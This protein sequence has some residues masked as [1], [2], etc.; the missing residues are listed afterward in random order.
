MKLLFTVGLPGSGK[1]TCLEN[2]RKDYENCGESV[3]I[4]DGDSFDDLNK[5]LDYVETIV[6]FNEYDNV[7]V[8]GLFNDKILQ[9]KIA[10]KYR[11]IVER[12]GFIYFIPNI[13]NCLFNDNLR[14]R[15]KK[16]RILIKNMKVD[17]PDNELIYTTKE[18]K[19]YN[20]IK[21]M[22]E[23]LDEKGIFI[24][25]NGEINGETISLG[26]DWKDC[27]DRGGTIEAD[28]VTELCYETFPLYYDLCDILKIDPDTYDYIVEEDEWCET[29]WYGGSYD[30]MSYK[31]NI[32][33][34]LEK[35]FEDKCFLNE[36]YD[37]NENPNVDIY[38]VD[39]IKERFSKVFNKN[40]ED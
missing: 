30:E 33:Y 22:S 27:W 10:T 14:D 8:D 23:N 20:I 36:D 5:L 37:E 7:Y 28:D 31:I 25:D 34:L 39:K 32:N 11:Y 35:V 17:K 29:D 1:T 26:G 4:I 12:F 9:N 3:L 24:S 2:L 13:E 15:E 6:K 40:K 19:K 18:V 38:D 21:I 16:S